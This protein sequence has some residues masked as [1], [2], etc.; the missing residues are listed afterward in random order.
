MRSLLLRGRTGGP[1]SVCD[2]CVLLRLTEFFFHSIG[3]SHQCF[4]LR[5]A[6]GGGEMKGTKSWRGAL[7]ALEDKKEYRLSRFHMKICECVG[8]G[9]L[10]RVKYSLWFRE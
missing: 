1:G 2:V 9:E 5:V 10:G 6:D 3:P 7:G 4:S 8:A